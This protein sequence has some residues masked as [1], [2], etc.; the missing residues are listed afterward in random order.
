LEPKLQTITYGRDQ[1]CK[2][3]WN[4]LKA[5]VMHEVNFIKSMEWSETGSP[6]STTNKGFAKTLSEL[7]QKLHWKISMERQQL[8]MKISHRLTTIWNHIRRYHQ[9]Q[10]IMAWWQ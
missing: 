7:D 9:R 6:S 3:L 10:L 2:Q 4:S 5:F 1:N 8:R